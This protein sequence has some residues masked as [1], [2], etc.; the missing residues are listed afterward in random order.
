MSEDALAGLVACYA[1]GIVITLMTMDA[2]PSHERFLARRTFLW[3][4]YWAYL[5]VKQAFKL[6]HEVRR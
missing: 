4:L 3:P 5:L 2:F 6:A 1:L